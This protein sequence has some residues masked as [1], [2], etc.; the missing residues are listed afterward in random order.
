ML[1]KPW[2]VVAAATR[3]GGRT[4]FR[5]RGEVLARV[6]FTRPWPA[7]RTVTSRSPAFWASRM[8]IV[9]GRGAQID[10]G[11]RV[12][13]QGG[14][15]DD[16]AGAGDQGRGRPQGQDRAERSLPHG[17]DLSGE[18]EAAAC[19]GDRTRTAGPAGHSLGPRFEPNS[20]EPNPSFAMG[21]RFPPTFLTFRGSRVFERVSSSFRQDAPTTSDEPP[22]RPGPAREACGSCR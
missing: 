14:P 10:G 1:W 7:P 17:E 4:T 13:G 8:A 15:G 20:S 2:P 16:E 9:D 19:R 22:N 21:A 5:R 6:S 18:G 3:P 12:I 11:R